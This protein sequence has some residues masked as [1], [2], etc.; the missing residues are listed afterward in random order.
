MYDSVNKFGVLVLINEPAPFSFINSVFENEIILNDSKIKILYLNGSQVNGVNA[1]GLFCQSQIFINNV[2]SI[3]EIN[4]IS[5]QID[6]SL[7]C[8]NSKFTRVLD[9]S[10]EV[11]SYPDFRKSTTN[12]H[13]KL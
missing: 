1:Q 10:Y 12:T 11:K 8:S 3:R 5:A 4:F 9:K 7:I 6:G 2:K 13:N